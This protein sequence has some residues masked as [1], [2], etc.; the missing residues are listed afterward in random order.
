MRPLLRALE[1]RLPPPLLLLLLGIGLWQGAHA[2]PALRFALPGA[3]WIGALLG[4]VGVALNLVPKWRFGQA[5]T[6]INPMR[7][8]ATQ[9]LVTGGL[10]ARSRNPMYVG[11]VLVLAGWGLALRTGLVLPAVLVQVLWLTR[12]Q[13]V[14]EERALQ[15]RFGEAY[16]DYRRRVRRWL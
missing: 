14:P 16:A 15:A 8:Q 5:G 10:L 11:Q 4:L 13:I 12:L 9:A 2:W 6:T 7:P 3:A 1:T